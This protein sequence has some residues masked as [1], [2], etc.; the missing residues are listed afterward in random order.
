MN[1][2]IREVIT[3]KNIRCGEVKIGHNS[4]I[5]ILGAYSLKSS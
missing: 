4:T 2:K 5:S 3:I 1:L